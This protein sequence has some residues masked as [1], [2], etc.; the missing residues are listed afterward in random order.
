MRQD[1]A[2]VLDTTLHCC[3]DASKKILK[4]YFMD[5]NSLAAGDS[6]QGLP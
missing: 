2:V 6:S 1:T 4:Y 3:K 5:D